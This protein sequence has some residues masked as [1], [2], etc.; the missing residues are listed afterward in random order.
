M[1]FRQYSGSSFIYLLLYV[2]DMLIAF[3][4]KSLISKLKSQLSEEFETKDLGTVKKI[5]GMKIQRDRNADKLYFSQGRYLDKVLDL[6]N[7]GNYKAVFTPLAAHFRLSAEYCPQFEEDIERMSNV[8]YSSV[9]G[10]L[11]FAMVCTRLDL[12]HAVSV[13]SRYMY[14]PGKDYWEAMK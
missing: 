6:F 10:S 13:V 12:S 3:K 7:M 2:D 5:L 8:P 9:V 11:I 14:N 4:D 1:Y